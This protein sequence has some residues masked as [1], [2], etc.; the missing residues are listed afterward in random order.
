MGA[1]LFVVLE[2]PI[3]GIDPFATN[4]K[5]LARCCDV[6]RR[7]GLPSHDMQKMM[8]AAQLMMSQQVIGTTTY[9]DMGYNW[10]RSRSSWPTRPASGRNSKPGLRKRCSGRAPPDPW[11]RGGNR[12][13]C[14]VSK[15]RKSVNGCV[16]RPGAR[17][18][19]SR[20]RR[21]A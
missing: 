6:P 16:P 14:R 20:A 12:V 3:D 4:G 5:A 15:A 21:P 19:R 17:A 8:I 13:N 2:R 9:G 1:A 11:R 7:T 18:T 10:R